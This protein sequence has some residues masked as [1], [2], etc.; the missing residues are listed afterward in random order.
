MRGDC[1][2]YEESIDMDSTG[3]NDLLNSG[4]KNMYMNISCALGGSEQIPD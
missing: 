3:A 2:T 1:N 4:V